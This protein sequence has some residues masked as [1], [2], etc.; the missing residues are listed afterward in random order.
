MRNLPVQARHERR[1]QVIRLR[2]AGLTYEAIAPQA[3]LSRTGVFNICSRYEAGG[4]DA[5]HDKT[6]G[7][8]LGEQRRLDAEQESEI[9][10]L[11][12]DKQ[13]DQLQLRCN[14]WTPAAVSHLVTQRT[15][16]QLPVRTLG[17]YLKRWG[18]AARKPLW[19]TYER[20]PAALRQWLEKDYPVIAKRARADDALILWGDETRLHSGDRRGSGIAPRGQE[21]IVG[22]GSHRNALSIVSAVS[23]KGQMRWMIF[24]G[25]M[26]TDILI[27]FMR[28]LVKGTP[29]KMFL[30]LNNLRVHHSKR[31]KAGLARHGYEIE[32]FYLPSLVAGRNARRHSS[33]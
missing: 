12:C 16:I 9:R 4:A 8:K 6:G 25:A 20:S 33:S 27:D 21:A 14:L 7:R 28:R 29:R 2:Q 22:T 24:R 32:V 23:N 11:I 15:G 1:V 30:I 5:L 19:Q 10:R 3:G 18:F 26:N 31:I 13:P 17:L